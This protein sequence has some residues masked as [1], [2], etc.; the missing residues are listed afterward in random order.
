M[1]ISISPKPPKFPNNLQTGLIVTVI[2]TYMYLMKQ[3][4]DNYHKRTPKQIYYEMM[5][6][7][8]RSFETTINYW[9][10]GILGN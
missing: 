8:N 9:K 5:Y 4:E 2:G 10:Y 3:Y 6:K 1:T 7:R